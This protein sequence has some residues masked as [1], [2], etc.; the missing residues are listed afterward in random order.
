MTTSADDTAKFKRRSPI[1]TARSDAASPPN[2]SA[3]APARS[4][5]PT[6][7]LNRHARRTY[8]TATARTEAQVRRPSSIAKPATEPRAAPPPPPTAPA[9]K[10]NRPPDVPAGRRRRRAQS[11]SANLPR[12]GRRREPADARV[13]DV[14]PLHGPI[15]VGFDLRRGDPRRGRGLARRK[16]GRLRARARAARQW[17]DSSAPPTCARLGSTTD[18]FGTPPTARTAGATSWSSIPNAVKGPFV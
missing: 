10:E 18:A 7:G 8:T 1:G 4:R 2:A 5:P 3:N 12:R 11:L 16:G 6:S 15:V 17:A 14:M 13:D 9:C